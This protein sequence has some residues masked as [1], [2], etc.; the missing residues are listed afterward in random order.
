MPSSSQDLTLH[1][2]SPAN[3]YMWNLG[4]NGIGDLICKAEI[5]T[6]KYRS[7]IWIPRGEG[8]GE[9]NR[10]TGTDKYTMDTMYKIGN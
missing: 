10:Q 3:T 8:A 5:E 2:Q 9:M 6:Q 1:G 7:N 4:K